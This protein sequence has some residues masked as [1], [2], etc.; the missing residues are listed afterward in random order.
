MIKGEQVSRDRPDHELQLLVVG[1]RPRSLIRL[2]DNNYPRRAT[3]RIV[4]CS[5]EEGRA[6]AHSP[7]HL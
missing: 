1:A 6:R 2:V 4:L 3:D 5:F 7:E